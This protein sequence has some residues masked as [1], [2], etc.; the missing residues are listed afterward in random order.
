VESRDGEESGSMNRKLAIAVVLVAAL[1]AVIGSV[2]LRPPD[3]LQTKPRREWKAAAVAEI[4]R[5]VVDTNWLA[6]EVATVKSQAAKEPAESGSWF[7]DHLILMKNGEWLVCASK[8][9]KEDSRIHDI[10]LGR[11][12]DGRW[13][14]ST[15]HF[16]I[17]M[18]TLRMDEQPE[19]LSDFVKAYFLRE[20]DGQSD[21]CLRKTWPP[22]RR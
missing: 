7:S 4:T 17:G 2:L 3:R 14:Y 9:A 12:S 15:F 19:S 13:Y 8:C 6:A 10:F 22:N 5:R 18:L 20:F 11:G 16:C 21:D 1:L